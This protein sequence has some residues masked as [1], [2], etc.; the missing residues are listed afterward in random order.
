MK[1]LSNAGSHDEVVAHQREHHPLVSVDEFG[2]LEAYCTYLSHL[3]AYEEAAARTRGQ[4]VLDCGCNVGYGTQLLAQSAVEVVGVDVSDRAVAEARVRCPGLTFHRVDGISLPFRRCSFDA[5]VSLQ[6]I[7]HVHDPAPYLSEIR[8]VLT[9]G[10]Q[11]LITTPNAGI[12]VPPGMRPWNPFH[13]TEFS[14]LEL[15]SILRAHFSDVAVLGLVGEGEVYAT[16]LARNRRA[17]EAHRRWR[18]LRARMRRLVPPSLIA[19]LRRATTPR[20]DAARAAQLST[21]EL[22]YRG[23]GLELA[24]DLLAICRP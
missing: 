1:Q 2:S 11:A 21:S 16:E 24:I 13:V 20:L 18:G 4:R 10:G 8:R 19:R 17:F 12:R 6:V 22:Y 5:V 9:D 23:H 3:R 15:E 14:P 7:E